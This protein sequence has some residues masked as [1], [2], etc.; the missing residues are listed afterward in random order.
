M[1]PAQVCSPRLP[2]PATKLPAKANWIKL[3]SDYV[4][5]GLWGLFTRAFLQQKELQRLSRTTREG[6]RERDCSHEERTGL[7]GRG[8]QREIRC[9]VNKKAQGLSCDFRERKWGARGQTL[10]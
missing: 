1:Q 3:R 8:E 9:K 6:K 5:N 2:I 7:L 4:R 10:H